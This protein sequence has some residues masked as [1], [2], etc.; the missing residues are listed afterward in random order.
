MNIMPTAQIRQI[1]C[2]K[3]GNSFLPQRIPGALIVCP[4]VGCNNAFDPDNLPEV[5]PDPPRMN[6]VA[7]AVAGQADGSASP[8][9][10]GR[11][12]TGDIIVTGVN[13]SPSTLDVPAM[14]NGR[15][16]M[17]V[18][19]RAFQDQTALR[20]V[21]LPDTVAFIGEDAFAG[22]LALESVTFGAGLT[23]LDMGC[24]R[25][26]E[27]LDY[28]ALPAKVQEI[29]RDAFARCSCLAEVSLGGE[30][31]VIRDGAFSLCEQLSVFTYPT[32]PQRVASGAFSGCYALPQSVQD[33]LFS[34][35]CP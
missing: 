32:R 26:C 20:R 12:D 22:C 10:F 16:V 14:V 31:K 18:G 27:S 34:T 1:R 8:L 13:G 3:C 28:V 2:L 30:V 23:L 17:G 25:D 9:V 35:S 21:T 5:F 19:P 11:S 24:F 15:A 29:G 33:A 6:M 4:V 7:G